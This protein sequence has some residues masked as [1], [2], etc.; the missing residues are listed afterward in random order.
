MIRQR[1]SSRMLSAASASSLSRPRTAVGALEAEAGQRGP[2]AHVDRPRRRR[3]ALEEV[4]V[5]AIVAESHAGSRAGRQR[6]EAAH[7][8]SLVR[9]RGRTSTGFCPRTARS[10]VSASR[11]SRVATSS[12]GQPLPELGVGH[13]V[14][15]D[16]RVLLL[17]HE[18]PGVRSM[19]WSRT[20]WTR[21]FQP[22]A[23][24][25]GRGVHSPSRGLEEGAVLGGE[26]Q[27]S[28][29]P[30]Q[31][32]SCRRGRPE[33]RATRGRAAG[34]QPPEDGEARAAA[35]GTAS[36]GRSDE[37]HQGPVVVRGR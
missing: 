8:L 35:G 7:D 13:S 18:A 34:A 14:V 6:L 29:R 31:R 20:G 25:G 30:N 12:F 9:P 33:T 23:E 27:P 3:K 1:R 11:S 32:S 21:A 2:L 24:A 22:G 37:G 28:T 26:P 17:L 10:S 16:Q 4:L 5:G 15:P 19:K 36:A